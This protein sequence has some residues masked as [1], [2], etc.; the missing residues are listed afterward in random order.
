MCLAVALLAMLL[1]GATVAIGSSSTFANRADGSLDTFVKFGAT[2]PPVPVDADVDDAQARDIDEAAAPV[3]R[4]RGPR[5][6][7]PPAECRVEEGEHEEE[8]Q[9]FRV[10]L[11]LAILITCLLTAFSL[12]QAGSVYLHESGASILLGM[13]VGAVI[14]I[15]AQFNLTLQ[16]VVE[17]EPSFFLLFLLPPIIFESGYNMNKVPREPARRGPRARVC[18]S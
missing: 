3:A 10:L 9:S 12:R 1:I 4:A 18:C 8:A 14:W 15:A 11:L 6:A 17:F 2:N 5:R 13:A 16:E 7:S